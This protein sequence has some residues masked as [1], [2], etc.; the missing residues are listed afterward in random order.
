MSSDNDLDPSIEEMYRQ[1]L[2]DHWR[3]PQNKGLLVDFSLEGHSIN[4]LC[5]DRLLL[6]VKLVKEKVVGVSFDGEG[7][8]I[9]QASASILTEQLKGKSKAYLQNL[10]QEKVLALLPIQ[11][12]PTRLKCALLPLGALQA[13][14]S[15]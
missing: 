14:L 6:R 10:S 11:V 3:E 8:A 9:S 13:A 4:Q 15:V 2:L 5:G 7:C 12:I 1:V